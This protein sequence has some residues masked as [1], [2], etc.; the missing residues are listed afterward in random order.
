MA[1]SRRAGR[2]DERIAVDIGGDG[3]RAVDRQIFRR[4]DSLVHRNWRIVDRGHRDQHRGHGGAAMTVGDGVSE[5]GRAVEVECWREGHAARCI[6][7]N[8]AVRDLYRGA[9]GDNGVPIDR[10]NGQRVTG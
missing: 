4:G 6:E 3:E 8:R 7:R 2:V 10:R 5:R 1:R 9:S